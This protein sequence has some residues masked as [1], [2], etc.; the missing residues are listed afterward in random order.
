MA[1]YHQEGGE[2]GGGSEGERMTRGGEK[3]DRVRSEYGRQTK[4]GRRGK[5]RG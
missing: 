5:D 1:T 4:G 3:M 2:Y